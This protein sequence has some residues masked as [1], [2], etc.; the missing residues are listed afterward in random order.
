MLSYI[1]PCYNSGRWIFDAVASL[2]RQNVE[3]WEACL[4]DDASTDNTRD[5]IK[6]LN[7]S[8]PT[9]IKVGYHETN[10]GQNP[11][12]TDCINMSKGNLIFALDHDNILPDNLMEKL[13]SHQKSTGCQAVSVES[14]L[15]FGKVDGSLSIHDQW[16]FHHKNYR[17]G[18]QEVVESFMTPASGGN[19][20]FTKE[21][22]DNVGGY[23]SHDIDLHGDWGFCLNHVEKGYD[24]SILPNSFYYHRYNGNGMYMTIASNPE[25]HRKLKHQYKDMFMQKIDRFDQKSQLMI[26]KTNDGHYLIES[27]ELKIV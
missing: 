23:L 17:V 4:V 19:Y 2:Y 16:I 21:M 15:F 14:L 18:F 8:D 9:H 10:K 7:I 5:N 6:I 26:I 27:G 24:I 25:K 22:Y 20:L 13:I 11:T 3:E 12:K 1:I